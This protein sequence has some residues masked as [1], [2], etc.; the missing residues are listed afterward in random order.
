MTQI[1]KKISNFPNE[2]V[3]NVYKGLKIIDERHALAC[4]LSILNLSA[5][6]LI[7]T[8]RRKVNPIRDEPP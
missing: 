8:E 3:K 7:M 6:S 2:D 4:Y 5:S 1:W